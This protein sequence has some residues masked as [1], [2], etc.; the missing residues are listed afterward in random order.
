MLAK[1]RSKRPHL[2]LLGIAN[3]VLLIAALATADRAR[4]LPIAVVAAIAITLTYLFVWNRTAQ[5]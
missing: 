1:A 5:H 2:V 4:T 3:A